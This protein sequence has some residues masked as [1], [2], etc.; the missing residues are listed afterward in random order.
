MII[1]WRGMRLISASTWTAIKLGLTDLKVCV[2]PALHVTNE[3]IPYVAWNNRIYE[4]PVGLHLIMSSFLNL[5]CISIC[6]AGMAEWVA[7]V[8]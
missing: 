4:C 5:K 8:H 1:Y 6:G 3:Y 2:F 7:A